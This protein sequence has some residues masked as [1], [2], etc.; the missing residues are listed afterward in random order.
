[1]KAAS[2][3]IRSEYASEDPK[4]GYDC[5][6]RA[7]LQSSRDDP[8]PCGPNDDVMARIREKWPIGWTIQ[9]L[10]P[11]RSASMTVD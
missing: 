8:Q 1:M 10:R 3:P 5:W 6:F 7:K 11:S 2:A 9:Q 4:A